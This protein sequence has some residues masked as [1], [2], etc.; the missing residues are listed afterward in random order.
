MTENVTVVSAV[1]YGTGRQRLDVYRPATMPTPTA[2]PVVLLWH[3][4]GPDERDV[5]APLARA[6]AALGVVCFVPD[7]HPDADDGGRGQL[8]ESVDFVR[9][10]AAS[11]GGDPRRITLAGWSLGGNAA[12]AAA[13]DPQALED[14]RPHA[15]VGIAGHYTRPEPLTGRA[16]LDIP[17][18]AADPLSATPAPA[19]PVHL[20]HGTADTLADIEEARRLHTALQRQGRPSSLTEPE[21]D[22]AGVIMTEY[23][24]EA[25]RCLPSRAAHAVRA[26]VLTAGLLAAATTPGVPGIRTL[27]DS[28]RPSGARWNESR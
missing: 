2:A 28:P 4:S 8:R 7:W 12:V 5:L 3:G 11:F 6:A 27:P 23:D 19:V 9:H 14:W 21:T 15:V 26:G 10:G 24:P 20:I 25:R 18:G 1:S 13:L 22:H 16:P 17:T